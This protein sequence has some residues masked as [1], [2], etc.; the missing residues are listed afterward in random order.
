MPLLDLD[1]QVEVAD[2]RCEYGGR[3]GHP[4]LTILLLLN[5]QHVADLHFLAQFLHQP[6]IMRLDYPELRRH[7]IELHAQGGED[8]QGR[9]IR[10][11]MLCFGCISAME[12]CLHRGSLLV[13]A[14]RA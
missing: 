4:P 7:R 5:A 2:C 12:K 11:C 6:L 1:I 8:D 14:R 3:S 13:E 10:A 9:Y